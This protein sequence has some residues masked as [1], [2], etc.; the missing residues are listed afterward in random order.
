[1]KHSKHLLCSLL[2]FAM[3]VIS[4]PSCSSDE[5][6]PKE[7]SLTD[8]YVGEFSGQL[9]LNIAG[10]YDYE[11]DIRII[12]SEGENETLG[13]A[14]PEYELSNTLM[15][16]ITMGSLILENL[17]YDPS[18]GGFYLDYGEAVISQYFKAESNGTVTMD[19]QY[20]LNAPSDIFV[21]KGEDGNIKVVNSFRIGA[22]PM[23]ITVTFIGH[24]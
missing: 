19:N 5:D 15:G 8:E 21:T 20:K 10:Q 18:K 17:S 23:P 11:T 7:P 16:D 3:T 4:L 6:E 9:T 1:M 22:M 2:A 24:K 13:I 12:I 14:F